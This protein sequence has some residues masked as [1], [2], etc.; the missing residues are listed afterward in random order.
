MDEPCFSLKSA[1]SSVRIEFV[2]SVPDGL[3]D[4]DGSTLDITLSGGAVHASVSAYDVR[5]HQW[6]EFFATLASD[7]HSLS[8]ELEHESLEGHLR[9]TATVDRLGHVTLRVRLCGGSS[10]TD[11][12][13]QDVIALEIGQLESI[14]ARARSFFRKQRT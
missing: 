12:M 7:W 10:P 5:F 2:G 8:G 13:A 3:N 9:L 14:A 6:A 1:D 4:W 11:W